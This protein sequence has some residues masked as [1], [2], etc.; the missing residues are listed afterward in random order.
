MGHEVAVSVLVPVF[1]AEK[2]IERSARSLFE[3]T[4]LKGVEYIFVN[5]GTPDDSI[6]ILK[7]V[8]SE[9]PQRNEQVRILHH[10]SNRGVGASRLTALTAACGKYIIFC[11]SDDYFGSEMLREMVKTVEKQEADMVIADYYISYPKKEKLMRVELQGSLEERMTGL[12]DKSLPSIGYMLWNKLIKKS[13]CEMIPDLF[14]EG[15]DYNED[16]LAV[17]KILMQDPVIVKVDGA[18][19]HYMIQTPGSISKTFTERVIR[20]HFLANEELG[21]FENKLGKEYSQKLDAKR[22]RDRLTGLIHSRGQLQQYCFNLY[23]TMK[24]G[25][26]K[27]EI[28]IYWRIPYRLALSGSIKAFNIL[29]DVMLSLKSIIIRMDKSLAIPRPR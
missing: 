28:P 25:D 9:Y 3:Q 15:L 24:Y 23:P 17:S 8:I 1:G 12:L 4:M 27:R 2:Y 5:D 13:L 10:E 16:L 26:Y 11:D 7:K 14:K 29:R 22:Y 20:N 18:Y 21:R 6:R 19:A